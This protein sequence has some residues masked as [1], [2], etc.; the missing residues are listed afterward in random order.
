MK[1][2]KT[3]F[4]VGLLA[5]LADMWVFAASDYYLGNAN[6]M[7]GKRFTVS[8]SSTNFTDN[9][10]S[11]LLDTMRDKLAQNFQEYLGMTEIN[12]AKTKDFLKKIQDSESL[13]ADENSVLSANFKSAEYILFVDVRRAGAGS[14]SRYSITAKLS[15]VQ[16]KETKTATE[17]SLVNINDLYSDLVVGKITK[18]LAEGFGVKLT[19]LALYKLNPSGSLFSVEEQLALNKQAQDAAARREAEIQKSLSSDPAK[20]AAQK[21]IYESNK[22]KAERDQKILQERLIKEQEEARLRAGRTSSVNNAIAKFSKE[23]DEALSRRPVSQSINAEDKIINVELKKAL[24]VQVRDSVEKQKD[25]YKKAAQEQYNAQKKDVYDVSL[26]PS[27]AKVESNGKWVI[28]DNDSAKNRRIELEKENYDLKAKI[29][30]STR[31]SI[32]ELEMSTNS[33]I[34]SLRSAIEV[35]KKDFG[36]KLT[37]SSLASNSLIYVGKW[38]GE[39]WPLR[40]SVYLGN[41]S[42]IEDTVILTDKEFYDIYQLKDINGKTLGIDDAYDVFD[43]LFRMSVPFFYVEV[44]YKIDPMAEKYASCYTVTPLEYR[45]YDTRNSSLIKKITPTAKAA[46]LQYR[47]ATDIRTNSEK[48]ADRSA[49]YAAKAKENKSLEASAVFDQ[50]FGGG[51]RSSVGLNLGFASGL[52]NGFAVNFDWAVGWASW[53]YTSLVIGMTPSPINGK[54]GFDII[55][56]I[57][58]NARIPLGNWYPNLY[59]DFG[60]GGVWWKYT[61]D[62]RPL[63]NIDSLPASVGSGTETTACVLLR[64][65]LGVDFP[66]ANYWAINAQWALHQAL[67]TSFTDEFTVGVRY[68]KWR[69]SAKWIESF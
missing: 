7:E 23:I 3:F 26:Y 67:K 2:I 9:E 30:A 14:G 45:I 25:A 32:A 44:D 5:L 41:I 65:A 64:Y 43:S 38:T 15:N 4:M 48:S 58:L 50:K 63:L 12:D 1:S 37:V 60:V 27:R 39:S 18:T 69:N 34:S 31:Q 61:P 22:A 52:Q 66:V 17:S 21:L 36:K 59:F 53:L 46:G 10:K 29:D 35:D 11:W 6:G 47:P 13:F 24:Y 42:F 16:T 62:D 33:Q 28:A 40:I 19:S 49:D 56:T 8:V 51:A 20:A 54:L 57:G 55:Q 68:G